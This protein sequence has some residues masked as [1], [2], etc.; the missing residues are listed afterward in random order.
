MAKTHKR[1]IGDAGEGVVCRYLEGKGY[2][3]VGRNYWKPWGEIDIVAEKGDLTI[4]IEVKTVSREMDGEG[5]SR[6]TFRPEEN[7]HPDKVK[8][9]HR[10]IQTYLLEKKVPEARPWR[11]DLACAYLDF[12][13]LQARVEMLENVV[14]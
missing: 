8:R 11:L 6:E 13:T 14:L 2:R 5:I 10:T 4:F 9:L 12:K 3:I 1:A 7:M